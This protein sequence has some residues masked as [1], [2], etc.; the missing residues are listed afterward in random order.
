MKDHES[1]SQDVP[2]MRSGEAAHTPGPWRVAQINATDK[3][4]AVIGQGPH[5]DEIV[6]GYLRTEADARLIAA[7]PDMLAALQVL[8]ASASYSTDA[9]DA[10]EAQARAAIAKAEGRS[11]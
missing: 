10:A 1:K 11:S 4:W 5:G 7:A 6:A 2:A 9:M 8:L 3:P